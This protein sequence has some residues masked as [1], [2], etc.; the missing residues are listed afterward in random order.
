MAAVDDGS[1][2]NLTSP[3]WQFFY[4]L[5]S[6]HQMVKTEN[7]TENSIFFKKKSKSYFENHTHLIK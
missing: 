6:K 2:A 1:S 7:Q 3:V 5:H 4:I